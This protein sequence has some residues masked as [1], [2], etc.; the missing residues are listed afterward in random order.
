MRQ[1]NSRAGYEPLR[2]IEARLDRLGAG[3]RKLSNAAVKALCDQCIRQIFARQALGDARHEGIHRLAEH[4]IIPGYRLCET[5]S[6]V[7]GCIHADDIRV[8]TDA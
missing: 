6:D 5:C 7:L 1:R 2:E 4:E 3:E 8:P